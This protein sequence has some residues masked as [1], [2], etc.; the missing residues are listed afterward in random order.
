MAY[1]K[2]LAEKRSEKI[3]PESFLENLSADTLT[4]VAEQ[5]IPWEI[6]T[7]P[8]PFDDLHRLFPLTDELRR[9]GAK[10]TRHA[11]HFAFGV[12]LNPEPPDADTTTIL[13][14][15]RA[16]I[17][18]YDWMLEREQTDLVRRLTPYI[19]HFDKPYL[20]TVLDSDYR[21]DRAQLIDDYL[22]FNPTRN[23]SLDMLPM[24]AHLDEHRVRERIDDQLIKAR[25]TFH[26]RLPN[27]DIDNPDWSLSEAWKLWL[28][29]ESLANDEKQLLQL[30]EEYSRE[31]TRMTRMLD[32]RWVER[33]AQLLDLE[34]P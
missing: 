20:R 15:L 18:L 16:F 17:C 28:A 10:G 19:R 1:L 8:I 30:C 13:S 32:Q 2:A 11:L 12:H 14:Y 27:C 7:S 31:L 33:V 29:V 21:P 22:D 24:F 23:R 5:F 34:T 9:L 3:E 6:V 4:V 26:F 25:P